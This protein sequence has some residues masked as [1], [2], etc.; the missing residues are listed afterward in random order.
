MPAFLRYV[1]EDEDVSS[2][3]DELSKSK[4]SLVV[5]VASF[6][7]R[8]SSILNGIQKLENE[9]DSGTCCGPP[10][11]S[12][13]NVIVIKTDES[14]ELEELAIELGL[15]DVPSYQIYRDGIMLGSSERAA[16][17]NVDTIRS[18]LK[19]AAAA[20]AAVSCCPPSTSS[21]SCCPPS[22]SSASCCPDGSA[23]TDAAD[24]LKL[25]QKSYAN[26]VNGEEGCCVSVQPEMLGYTQEQ[27]IKAGKDANLGLGCGNP[28]NFAN[29]QKGETV[30]DLGSGAGIDCFLAA[31]LVGNEGSIIGIDM[32]PDMI[33]K[34]RQNASNRGVKNVQFRLGEIEH[35]PVADNTV[36]VVISNCVI[37][38]SPDKPQVFREIYR[39]LKKGGRISISDVVIRPSAEPLP[40]SLKSA[41]ALAC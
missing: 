33:Y 18:Q 4:I 12:K 24:I 1:R 34:A 15:N 6:E 14:D 28:I 10:D 16:D 9:Y 29:I 8:C 26:T 31:D 21:I 38:L 41:E 7:R 23:P 20:T 32:T 27:I 40:E 37:N 25:V 30:V 22:T 19:S 17:V 35:L 13:P 5:A 36:D 3:Q 2:I 11:A 39:I